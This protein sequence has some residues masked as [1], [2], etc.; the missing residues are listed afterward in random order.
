MEGP[1]GAGA[2]RRAAKGRADKVIS[3]LLNNIPSTLPGLYI[4]SSGPFPTGSRQSKPQKNFGRTC[5]LSLL[6]T[7]FLN[8]DW[9]LFERE[10]CCQISWPYRLFPFIADTLRYCPFTYLGC[11][12]RCFPQGV[13][14]KARSVDKRTETLQSL[15]ARGKSKATSSN[16]LNERRD[17]PQ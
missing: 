9:F 5:V 1:H 11:Q 10:V 7:S 8:Q 12:A 6:L 16:T 3:A 15:G 4:T 13:F 17:L 2:V 14:Q